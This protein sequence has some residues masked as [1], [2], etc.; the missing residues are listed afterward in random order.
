MFWALFLRVTAPSLGGLGSV[1]LPVALG[2]V[3]VYFLLPRPQVTSSWAG[4]VVAAVALVTAG[5]LLIHDQVLTVHTL[6]FYCFSA[7]AIVSGGLLVTQRNP[8]RAALS[9]ALVVLSTC[10]LFLLQAAPFLMAATIIIYAGAIIVTFLF[11]IMLA[12]QAGLSD[13]DQRSREPLLT[14]VAGFALLSALLYVLTSTYDTHGLDQLLQVTNGARKLAQ[15]EQIR[16]ALVNE[17]EYLSSFRSELVKARVSP[18]LSK[19]AQDALGRVESNLRIRDV[20]VARLRQALDSLYDEGMRVREFYGSLQVPAASPLSPFSES[21]DPQGRPALPAENVA[22]LGRS[23]FTD[24]LLAVELG[25][26]L[27]LVATIGA[28]AIAG[29]REEGLR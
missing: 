21:R 12:Q 14:C 18:A 10:G 19:A 22:H 29:R 2:M 8:V 28:I 6:L 5:A 27:L 3:A 11:V 24:Y 26:T 23:L 16:T 7:I 25:G 15:I 1:A 13:A 20:D 17:E 4:A 9:F